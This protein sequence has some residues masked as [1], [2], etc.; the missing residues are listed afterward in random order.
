MENHISPSLTFSRLPT[1]AHTHARVQAH[2]QA[3]TGPAAESHRCCL[4]D[5]MI[6]EVQPRTHPSGTGEALALTGESV[7]L[8]VQYTGSARNSAGITPRKAEDDLD[9]KM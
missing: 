7:T 4:S 8:K 9:N 5:G 2:T 6:N 3:Q 1:H